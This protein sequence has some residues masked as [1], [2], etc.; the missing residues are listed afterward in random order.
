[1]VKTGSTSAADVAPPSPQI[2]GADSP[3]FLLAQV[4]GHAAGRFAERLRAEGL[5]PAHAGTLRILQATEGISQQALGTVLGVA[6]SRLV[7]L[8]DDLETRGLLERRDQPN[9]RRSYALHLTS[10]GRDVLKRIGQIA[11]EH[12]QALCAALSDTERELLADL[13]KRIAEEQGLRPGVHPGF[14]AKRLNGA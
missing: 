9:D 7:T 12:Q 8:I 4:G 5:V 6:P 2:R 10:K 1:M 11:R 14:G 13:L 3:A